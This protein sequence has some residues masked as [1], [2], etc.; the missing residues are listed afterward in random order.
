MIEAAGCVH[1]RHVHNGSVGR[2][3]AE[4]GAHTLTE[5]SWRLRGNL[6]G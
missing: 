6:V 5:A 3:E 4:A 2:S 1:I